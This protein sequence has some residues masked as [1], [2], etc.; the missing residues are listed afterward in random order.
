MFC[1]LYFIRNMILLRS[2]SYFFKIPEAFSLVHKDIYKSIQLGSYR[3]CIIFALPYLFYLNRMYNAAQLY[4]LSPLT[5]WAAGLK[6]V[7]I[8]RT[9]FLRSFRKC[10]MRASLK[11]NKYK[12]ALFLPPTPQKSLVHNLCH[13]VQWTTDNKLQTAVQKQRMSSCLQFTNISFH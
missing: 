4:T 8:F 10:L 6:G 2:P 12:F 11:T 7:I 1:Y 5:L 9:S 13:T 3:S